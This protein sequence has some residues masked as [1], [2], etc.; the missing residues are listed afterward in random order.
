MKVLPSRCRVECSANIFI[1]FK[2][3]I[4]HKFKSSLYVEEIDTYI[5]IARRDEYFI[6]K[7]MLMIL[8]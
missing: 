7:S 1:A 6:I 2:F 8:K 3:E 4:S 5:S